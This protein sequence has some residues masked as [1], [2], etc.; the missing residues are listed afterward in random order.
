MLALVLQE[1][2]EG[3]GVPSVDCPTSNSA[4]PSEKA[5]P[6]DNATPTD[7][8]VPSDGTAFS[9]NATPSDDVTPSDVPVSIVAT[10][11]NIAIMP[12]E[13][14][15]PTETPPL[16]HGRA[17]E[18][19]PVEAHHGIRF[20]AG[21]LEFSLTALPT[22]LLYTLRMFDATKRGDLNELRDIVESSRN[23]DIPV[24]YVTVSQPG[25]SRFSVISVS[26]NQGVDINAQYQ[27][28]TFSDDAFF[29]QNFNRR[30][31]SL[32]MAART[33][34]LLSPSSPVGAGQSATVGCGY[35]P[36]DHKLLLHIAI[37]KGNLEIVNYLLSQDANVSCWKLH[38][39]VGGRGA[40]L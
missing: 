36:D 28:P 14:C 32:Y 12:P 18:P 16:D 17:P 7:I 27:P 26:S 9:D 13:S 10:H 38:S 1:I 15:S 24:P 23:S 37:E 39:T 21:R 8:I 33:V 19:I 40:E 6:C 5:T 29:G 30:R 20:I 35:S 31:S 11:P 25:D 3:V 34:T 4:T 2:E 22:E